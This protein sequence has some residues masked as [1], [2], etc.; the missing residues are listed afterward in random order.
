MKEASA[1]M[2]ESV[3]A[4]ACGNRREQREAT[5]FLR[6]FARNRAT[7][8]AFGSALMLEKEVGTGTG[9]GSGSEWLRDRQH[10]MSLQRAGIGITIVFAIGWLRGI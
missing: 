6:E 7:A 8:A 1:L 5:G 4:T 9:T 10:E 3:A 2:V